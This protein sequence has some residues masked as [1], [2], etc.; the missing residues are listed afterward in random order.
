MLLRTPSKQRGSF[1]AMPTDCQ[2]RLPDVLIR[3][4]VGVLVVAVGGPLGQG[5]GTA[6]SVS[7]GCSGPVEAIIPLPCGCVACRLRDEPR[8]SLS[9]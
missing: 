7:G 5:G 4:L 9:K 8:L 1:G 6:D 2:F 3:R